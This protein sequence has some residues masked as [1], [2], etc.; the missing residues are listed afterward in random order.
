MCS[1]DECFSRR[2]TRVG[3]RCFREGVTGLV[4]TMTGGDREGVGPG[5]SGMCAGASPFVFS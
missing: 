3:S 4:E 2:L 5:V 1:R